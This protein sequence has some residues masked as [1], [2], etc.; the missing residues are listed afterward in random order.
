[1]SLSFSEKDYIESAIEK[2]SGSLVRAAYNIIGNRSEAEDVAQ[3]VFIKLYLKKPV[4][5]NDEHEKAWLLRVAINL[6]KNRI[7]QMKRIC[8]LDDTEAYTEAVGEDQQ[9]VAKA[10]RELDEKYRIVIHLHYY[11]GYTLR[12]IA[13]ILNLPLSTVGTRLERAKNKLREKLQSEVI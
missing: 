6:A 12:E 3:E 9:M 13:Q 2:Y 11:E 7:R 5:R 8:L 4:F 10:V 1:M